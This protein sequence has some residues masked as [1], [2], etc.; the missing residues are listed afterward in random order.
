[1]GLGCACALGGVCV[2]MGVAGKK[3]VCIP[4]AYVVN[5]RALCTR[6]STD[7]CAIKLLAVS[8]ALTLCAFT[9][10]QTPHLKPSSPTGLHPHPVCMGPSTPPPR[11]L[12]APRPSPCVFCCVGLMLSTAPPPPTCLRP[13]PARLCA[14][15]PTRPPPTTHA[16]LAPCLLPCRSDAVCC[17]HICPQEHPRQLC[18]TRPHP[19]PPGRPHHQQP[20]STESQ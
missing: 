1:M 4:P 8:S 2:C 11:P 20:S 9:P 18:G 17:G 10:R 16:P 15:S 3:L 7:S 14:C 19:H 13:Q 5:L 12:L 6:L